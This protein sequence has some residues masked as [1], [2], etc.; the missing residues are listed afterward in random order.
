MHQQLIE[1]LTRKYPDYEWTVERDVQTFNYVL[2][3]T[4]DGRYVSFVIPE[5]LTISDNTDGW[6]DKL[7]AKLDEELRQHNEQS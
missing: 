3:L 2:T 4:K 6:E 1:Q 7:V 5:M